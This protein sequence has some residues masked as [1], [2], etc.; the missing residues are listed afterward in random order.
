MVWVLHPR[1]GSGAA[2]TPPRRL[3][4]GPTSVGRKS[5][6]VEM[7]ADK[8]VSR[9]HATFMAAALPPAQLAD[10]AARP[11]LQL[12][13]TSSTGT[14]LNDTKLA[15]D[16][17]TDVA[18]GDRV[19]FGK[20]KSSGAGSAFVVRWEPLVLVTSQVK[21]ERT[22][23]L[24]AAC[25]TLG[26]HCVNRWTDESTHCVQSKFKMTE[27]VATALVD[28]CPVVSVEWVESLAGCASGPLSD[29]AE[30]AL[31][32]AD[33]AQT[34]PDAKRRTLF[35]GV[36][37]LALG[38]AA[39]ND[40]NARLVERAGGTTHKL[41]SAG[42]FGA[43][44]V[45]GPLL[46]MGAAAQ[47]KQLKQKHDI[48]AV[49][50]EGVLRC[51]LKK[52]L[53][54]L[55]EARTVAVEVAKAKAAA[56]KP[57]AKPKPKAS[58]SKR[59]PA[60]APRATGHARRGAAAVAEDEAAGE[61]AAD[62]EGA[63]DEGSDD[64]A[65]MAAAAAAKPKPKPYRIP[66]GLDASSFEP[67]RKRR[68][69]SSRPQPGSDDEE[70]DSEAASTGRAQE[71]VRSS[72]VLKKASQSAAPA[73]EAG[74]PHNFKRFRKGWAA[75]EAEQRK[76][77]ALTIH[78]D[79]DEAAARPAASKRRA[80]KKGAAQRKHVPVPESDEESDDDVFGYR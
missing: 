53:D 43:G 26:A 34:Q 80:P 28:G 10:A 13:D 33:A 74:A 20:P 46:C 21:A 29:P 48:E 79:G 12:T 16:E 11:A 52:S 17:A 31:A 76:F 3:F 25:C 14:M 45:E 39:N 73:P 41:K 35:E 40:I 50:M 55:P 66:G 63:D 2:G 67:V 62:D 47:C 30:F 65:P 15:K 19:F 71:V 49:D 60:A 9:R 1:D 38:S 64:E 68:T 51:I 8:S 59:K 37:F 72:A 24:H 57:A 58:A 6:D 56:T 75:G 5:A 70:R 32:G 69:G 77:P 78:C 44:S 42:K 22:A 36:T 4:A 18:E 23:A 27:K 7:P 54:V 61:E